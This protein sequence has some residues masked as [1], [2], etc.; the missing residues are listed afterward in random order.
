MPR[1]CGGIRETENVSSETSP[2]VYRRVWQWC[3]GGGSR[4]TDA[5][6]RTPTCSVIKRTIK[7]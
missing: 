4:V 7:Q 6:A 1:F 2:E 3:G 5:V